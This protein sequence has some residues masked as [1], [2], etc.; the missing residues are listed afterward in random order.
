[1][2][3][4]LGYAPLHYCA[5]NGNLKGVISLINMG[6]NIDLREN[7]SGRTPLF[8][9]LENKH[10]VVAQTLIEK[11]ASINIY[12]FYGHTILSLQI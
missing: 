11:G 12:N 3:Y 6:A 5:Q 10:A 1:M 8:L 7:R 2:F 9:A 4:F